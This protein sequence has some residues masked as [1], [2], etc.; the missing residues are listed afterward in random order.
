MVML[1][2]FFNMKFYQLKVRQ[3]QNYFFKMTLLPKNDEINCTT[4]KFQVDLF[5]FVFMEKIDDTKKTFQN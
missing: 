4:I 5:S 2:T 3:G 1:G